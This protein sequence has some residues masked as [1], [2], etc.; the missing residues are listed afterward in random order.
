[1]T[2][3]GRTQWTLPGIESYLSSTRYRL[4]TFILFSLAFLVIRGSNSAA[5]ILP[6]FRTHRHGQKLFGFFRITPISLVHAQTRRHT[7]S[8]GPA[9]R[10]IYVISIQRVLIHNITDTSFFSSTDKMHFPIIKV[11]YY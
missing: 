7:T 11:F 8:N 3:I 6:I 9:A 4:F 5:S 1:M 10:Y 2:R